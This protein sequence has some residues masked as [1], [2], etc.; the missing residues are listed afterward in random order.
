MST[1]E[2]HLIELPAGCSCT[3]RNLDKFIQPNILAIL[4]KQD[5]HGYLIIQELMK[6]EIYQQDKLDNT[7]IYRTL[8]TLEERGLVQS[9]WDVNET[10]PSKRVYRLTAE[11]KVCLGTWRSTLE[12]YQRQLDLII[13]EIKEAIEIG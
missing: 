11:G 10:G 1:I 3:G 12:S 7:G 2:E 4:A 8:K 5:L 9:D 6:K 13:E